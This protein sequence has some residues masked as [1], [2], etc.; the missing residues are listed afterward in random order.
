MPTDKSRWPRLGLRIRPDLRRRFRQLH[1]R[2]NAQRRAVGEGHLWKE[3]FLG[4][5]LEEAITARDGGVR[6]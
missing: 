1:A 2:E 5:L 4:V 3:D 6:R